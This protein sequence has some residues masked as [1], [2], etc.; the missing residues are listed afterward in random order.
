MSKPPARLPP[1]LSSSR[2]LPLAPKLT[3]FSPSPTHVLVRLAAEMAKK[4]QRASDASARHSSVLPLPGGPYS[5]KPRTGARRPVK[6]SARRLW[7]VFVLCVGGLIDLM[8]VEGERLAGGFGEK[9]GAALTRHALT[10]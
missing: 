4:V 2:P 3:S 5:S 1:P 10:N 7:F 8:M 9:E 6:M